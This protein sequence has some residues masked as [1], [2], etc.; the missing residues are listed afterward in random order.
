MN[1][2][3][4]ITITDRVFRLVVDFE[5]VSRFATDSLQEFGGRSATKDHPGWILDQD[6]NVDPVCLFYPFSGI[7]VYGNGSTRWKTRQERSDH[8]SLRFGFGFVVTAIVIVTVIVVILRQDG[9]QDRLQGFL[10]FLPPR[11]LIDLCEKIVGKHQ[12]DF[13]DPPG[14]VRR[15]REGDVVLVGVAGVPIVVTAVV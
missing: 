1:P 7:V 8:D 5:D 3:N 15:P 9:V 10:E 14:I 12:D 11:K 4:V 2:V 13:S 6:G